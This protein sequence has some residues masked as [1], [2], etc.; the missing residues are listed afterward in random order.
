MATWGDVRGYLFKTYKIKSESD[1]GRV[2]SLL[3][4]TGGGRSQHVFVSLTGNDHIGQ[5]V[6]VESVIARRDEVDIF[7][8]LQEASGY[9]CGAVA[10]IDEL[11]TLRDSFPLADLQI[12]E[13]EDPLH[14]VLNSADQL[15]QALVGVDHA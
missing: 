15:E 5:W 1:D 2:L 4:E 7:R 9:V 11:V 8:V 14:L 10:L 3:F 13:L 12:A 6:R